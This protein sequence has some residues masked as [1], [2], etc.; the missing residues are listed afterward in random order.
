MSIFKRFKLWYKK[1][2]IEREF[3]YNISLHGYDCD[4]TVFYPLPNKFDADMFDVATSYVS[5]GEQKYETIR[6]NINNS[7]KE[8]VK[9]IHDF[10]VDNNVDAHEIE[11]GN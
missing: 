9:I 8:I 10:F 1:E 4:Y 6:I 2:I 11:V 3:D 7:N 5:N